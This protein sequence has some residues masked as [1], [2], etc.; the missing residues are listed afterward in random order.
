ML[1]ELGKGRCWETDERQKWKPSQW[2]GFNY[3]LRA[4][5]PEVNGNY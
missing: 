1:E 4:T 3:V 2:L 5:G